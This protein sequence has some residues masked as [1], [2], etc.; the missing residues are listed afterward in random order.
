AMAP[1]TTW[2][3][4]AVITVHPKETIAGETKAGQSISSQGQS[5]S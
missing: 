4:E 5:A 3:G 1:E 2:L